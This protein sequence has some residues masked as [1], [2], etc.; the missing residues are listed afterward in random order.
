MPEDYLRDLNPWTPRGRTPEIQD[1][2]NVAHAAAKRI[3]LRPDLDD[4]ITSEDRD[5]L[6][7]LGV[8]WKFRASRT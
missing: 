5:I 3:F 8:G 1:A 7:S 6:R 2:I 4:Y